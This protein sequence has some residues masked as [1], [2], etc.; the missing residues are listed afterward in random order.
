MHDFA[1]ILTQ[2]DDRLSRIELALSSYREPQFQKEW[3]TVAEAAE[4]LG[5]APFT[6]RE[7][8]RL[9]R[10]NASKRPS[11]RGTSSEWM[12]SHSEI[13]RIQNKGLLPRD[14]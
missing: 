8:C 10:I 5:K 13:E 9:E 6:V 3:Y 14:L 4:I 11:G 2:L 12:I 7:W 1:D